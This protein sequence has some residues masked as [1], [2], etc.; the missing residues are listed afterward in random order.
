MAYSPKKR[1][2]SLLKRL[3]KQVKK[4]NA[5]GYDKQKFLQ[6]TANKL[7]NNK[8][9][10]ELEFEKMMNELNIEFEAQK[11]VGSKIFDYYIPSKNLLLEV[12]G[13]YF[14]GNPDKFPK[15]NRMQQR[16]QR[17]DKFKNTLAVSHGYLIE[18]V[19]ETDLK[20][21]YDLVKKRFS[22]LLA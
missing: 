9:W 3:K 5:P 17:N 22:I 13:C 4:H 15:P 1:V 12:D 19:W 2:S 7:K 16:N 8:T 21:H 6:K 10:P 20:E 11:I 14:H 18:R